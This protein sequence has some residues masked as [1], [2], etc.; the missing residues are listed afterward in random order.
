MFP[1]FFVREYIDKIFLLGG[2]KIESKF[3]ETEYFKSLILPFTNGNLE[4]T[5]EMLDY[6]KSIVHLGFK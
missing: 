5:Q 3:F 4:L 1:A 2:Y 6:I